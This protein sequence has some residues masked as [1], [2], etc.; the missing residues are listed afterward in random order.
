MPELK[1]AYPAF[2]KA[3]GGLEKAEEILFKYAE[4]AGAEQVT[5]YEGR[6]CRFFAVQRC[7]DSMVCSF[8]V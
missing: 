8:F 5:T 2:I 6:Q 3:N 1:E 7:L 4:W